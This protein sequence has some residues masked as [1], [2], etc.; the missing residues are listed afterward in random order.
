MGTCVDNTCWEVCLTGIEQF[1]RVAFGL[2]AP[3]GTTTTGMRWLGCDSTPNA[4]GERTCA[5]TGISPYVEPTK[6]WTAGPQASAPGDQLDHTLYVIVE[7]NRYAGSFNPLTLNYSNE[8]VCIGTLELDG[9]P[10]LEPA[11]TNRS[12]GSPARPPRR[13]KRVAR[14][15][16]RRSATSATW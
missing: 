11:L 7:G 16:G 1:H 2:I 13:S 3:T 10:D 5:A 4:S 8:P 15:W 9:S 12:G 14:W 6:S